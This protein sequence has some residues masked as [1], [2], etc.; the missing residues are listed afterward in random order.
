MEFGQDLI[1][2][3]RVIDLRGK[4]TISQVGALINRA[5]IFISNDS[6][7]VHIAAALMRSSFS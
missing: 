4:L 3:E 6:G 1:N 2:N 5:V 7:P